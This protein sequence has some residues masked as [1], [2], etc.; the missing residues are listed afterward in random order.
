MNGSIILTRRL[1]IQGWRTVGLIARGERRKEL[2]PI[3][4]RANSV[5]ETDAEDIAEH[6]LFAQSRKIVAERLLRIGVT[7][8]LL[9]GNG[10]RYTLTERG[11]KAVAD[12]KVFVPEYGAWNIWMS[13]DPLLSSPVLR[14]DAADEPGAFIENREYRGSEKKRIFDELPKEICEN[15]GKEITPPAS[16]D[17]VAVRIDGLREKAEAIDTDDASLTLVWKVRERQLRLQGEWGGRT[18][19]SGLDAPGKTPDEIW[20]DLLAGE[21]DALLASENWLGDSD[22]RRWDR[23]R[24]ALRVPFWRTAE[25]ERESM[26]CDVRFPAPSV[27]DFGK[28]DPLTIEGVDI[29]ALSEGDA[30]E[31]AIWRFR[32]RIRDFATAEHYNEWW[33]EAA[34]P[35]AEYYPEPP[36]RNRLARAEWGASDNAPTVRAWHLMAAEDWGL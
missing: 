11:E 13:R 16:V 25:R 36:S 31:W 15:Q 12:G 26:S 23:R 35:F 5:G 22:R 34:E 19:D 7:F 33:K 10:E 21:W 3:L 18:V 2:E 4:L 32:E 24:R 8:D 17:L 28:F 27:P 20:D 29:A 6:L 30:H 14:I 1:A 9:K